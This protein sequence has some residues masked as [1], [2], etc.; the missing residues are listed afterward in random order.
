[1]GLLCVVKQ[2]TIDFSAAAL[3]RMIFF[4]FD[5][6]YVDCLMTLQYQII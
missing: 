6:A 3:L 2:S 4:L 5:V 1:M